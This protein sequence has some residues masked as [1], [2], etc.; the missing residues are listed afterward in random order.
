[1]NKSYLF[2]PLIVVGI[3]LLGYGLYVLLVFIWNNETIVLAL[4]LFMFSLILNG[5]LLLY[6]S[7]DKIKRLK[8]LNE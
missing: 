3:L 7:F 8:K 1:M 2:I 4:W 6:I 5:V